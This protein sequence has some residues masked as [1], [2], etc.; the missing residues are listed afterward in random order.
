MFNKTGDLISHHISPNLISNIPNNYLTCTLY[1]NFLF[2]YLMSFAI[3]W[4]P[5]SHFERIFIQLKFEKTNWYQRRIWNIMFYLGVKWKHDKEPSTF[6]HQI[7]SH[8]LLYRKTK[9]VCVGEYSLMYSIFQFT[10]GETESII[11]MRYV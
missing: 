11:E 4:Y 1:S 7:L 10:S 8:T 9:Y 6:F 3:T 2:D 5:S